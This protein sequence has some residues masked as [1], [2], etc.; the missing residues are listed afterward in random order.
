MMSTKR[1]TKKYVEFSSISP[2]FMKSKDAVSVQTSNPCPSLTGSQ[3]TVCWYLQLRLR[4]QARILYT[5]DVLCRCTGRGQY[6]AQNANFSP[7][8]TDA[9]PPAWRTQST[10]S[11]GR[12]CPGWS[13]RWSAGLDCGIRRGLNSTLH[14]LTVVFQLYSVLFSNVSLKYSPWPFYNCVN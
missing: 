9:A 12:P 11:W 13:W 4:A 6:F 2:A 14:F 10:G 7:L 5:C 1:W 3:R 8:I